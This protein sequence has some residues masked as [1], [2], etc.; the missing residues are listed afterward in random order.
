[1]RRKLEKARGGDRAAFASLAAES[2]AR[3]FNIA[4]AVVLLNPDLL[5]VA[6]EDPVLRP[7]V[8]AADR[9]LP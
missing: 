2:I 7:Q 6:G 9:P 1:M 3:L 5:L 8:G 4:H